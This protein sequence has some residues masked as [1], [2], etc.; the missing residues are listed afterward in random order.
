MLHFHK[1][2]HVIRNCKKRQRRN[3]RLKSAHVASTNEVSDQLVQFTT[4]KLAKFHLYQESLKSPSIPLLS[5]LSQ[6]TR[7]NVLSLLRPP[8]GSLALEL[9]ITC[10]VILAYSLP[11]SHILQLPMSLWQMGHSHVFLGRAQFFQL[12][13]DLCHPS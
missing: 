9:Q 2:G 11:F 10:Q 5:L 13:L 7:I 4:E 1:P 12:H 6:V 3:Q 8:N